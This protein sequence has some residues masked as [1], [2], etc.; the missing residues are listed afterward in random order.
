VYQDALARTRARTR[1][2]LVACFF[3]TPKSA[4]GVHVCA[5]QGVAGRCRVL[6]GVCSCPKIG[7]WWCLCVV[8]CVVV[9][10]RVLQGVCSCSE[11]G[12]V[13]VCVWCSVWQCVAGCCRVFAVALKSAWWCVCVAECCR[14]LQGVCSCFKV[15][16]WWCVC[17]MQCVFVV[18][19][20]GLGV[21]VG[22]NWCCLYVVQRSAV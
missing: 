9:Y 19:G 20:L 18:C 2:L 14:V 10:S 8:Q 11:V 3:I 17:V 1:P 6:H 5:M 4:V 15:G 13:V 12:M 16:S 22:C 7:S 21:A